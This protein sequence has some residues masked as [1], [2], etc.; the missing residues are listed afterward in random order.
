MLPRHA[1]SGLYPRAGVAVAV[2]VAAV[3]STACASLAAPAPLPPQ[4][5]L[6][7]VNGGE[8]VPLRGVTV[9]PS[10]GKE[11]RTDAHGVAHLQITGEE[12]ARIDLTVTCPDG[13]AA[14]VNGTKITVRRTSKPPE[15]DVPC[16]PYEHAILVAFKTTGASGVPILY[17]GREI[18]KTD[19]AGYALV[20]LEP[21]AGETLA[22]TL[23]TSDPKHKFLRPQNPERTVLAPDGSQG[24]EAFTIEQKF[25]E[26]KPKPK[27]VAAPKPILPKR[28]LPD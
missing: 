20:E 18:A 22:F 17:L 24:E 7:R 25:V 27:I 26:E 23:D 8:N 3:A 6:V 1:I 2:A 10:A 5:I 9:K 4:D 13:Y 16:R 11:G 19:E 21:K 28:L 15:F 12:G 14:P